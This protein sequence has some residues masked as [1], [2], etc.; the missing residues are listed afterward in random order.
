MEMGG[1]RIMFD[2]LAETTPDLFLLG[3]LSVSPG[4]MPLA[5]G[6]MLEG[7]L[8]CNSPGHALE[9]TTIPAAALFLLLLLLPGISPHHSAR[10][11]SH[12]PCRPRRRTR[13]PRPKPL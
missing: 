7:V 1:S 3:G 5:L 2:C 12:C 8:G 13:R 9:T 11:T 6:F 10:P 4:M